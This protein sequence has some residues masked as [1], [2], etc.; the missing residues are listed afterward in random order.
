MCPFLGEDLCA[1]EERLWQGDSASVMVALSINDN[2]CEAAFVG[3][4][5]DI[6]PVE[7]KPKIRIESQ[8]RIPGQDQQQFIERRDTGRQFMAVE[9]F[10]PIL[11]DASASVH[12]V[13][14]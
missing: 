3:L 5:A 14:R 9:K 1:A 13:A 8:R 11:D 12:S 4:K 2:D 7:V 10:V 6:C